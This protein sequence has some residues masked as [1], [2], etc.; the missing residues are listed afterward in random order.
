MKKSIFILAALLAATVA[1]AQ[2]TLLHLIFP[3]ITMILVGLNT[4]KL[5]I[6]LNPIKTT[7]MMVLS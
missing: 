3:L 6:S 7:T 4:S 2:I 1:N 5:H